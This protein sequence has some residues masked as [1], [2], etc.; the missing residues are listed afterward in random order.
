MF[1][2]KLTDEQIREIMNLISDDGLV[3]MIQVRSYDGGYE[4]FGIAYA[5]SKIKDLLART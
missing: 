1:V 4:D 2:E 5:E 3:R